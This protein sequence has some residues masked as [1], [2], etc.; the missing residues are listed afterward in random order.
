M[1]VLKSF[2]GQISKKTSEKVQISVQIKNCSSCTTQIKTFFV[3]TLCDA[4]TKLTVTCLVLLL[5]T[6]AL[7]NVVRQTDR[8]TNLFTRIV[9][10]KRKKNS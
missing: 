2:K 4:E 7:A 3:S 10:T 8:L 6:Y 5:C 9:E 1:G